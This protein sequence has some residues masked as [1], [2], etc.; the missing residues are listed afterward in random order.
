[1]NKKRDIETRGNRPLNKACFR[2]TNSAGFA[3]VESRC[4]PCRRHRVNAGGTDLK[5]SQDVTCW[6]PRRK[7]YVK[8]HTL[9]IKRFE[10]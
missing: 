1:M 3:W 2:S 10:V 9:N 5:K 4:Y 8:E 6:L 7:I